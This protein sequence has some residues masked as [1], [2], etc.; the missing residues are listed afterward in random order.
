MILSLVDQRSRP[1]TAPLAIGRLEVLVADLGRAD[2]H[3][4]LVLVDDQTMAELNGRWYGGKGPTDVLSFSYL[5]EA[6]DHPVALAAGDGGAARD[7]AVAPEDGEDGLTA[8]EVIVAPAFVAARCRREGWD[9]ADEW[10]LLLVHGALHVLGWTHA[11]AGERRVMR[12][13]EAASLAQV[14]HVHPLADEEV[15]D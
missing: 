9:L 4:N 1:E 15:D 5:E 13:Q 7:L 11:T 12:A 10:A 14:G 8:G 2:W 6:G 3:L